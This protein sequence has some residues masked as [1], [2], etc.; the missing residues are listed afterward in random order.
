MVS[1]QSSLVQK[2]VHAV[3][4]AAPTATHFWCLDVSDCGLKELDL[5]VSIHPES[6]G[7]TGSGKVALAFGVPARDSKPG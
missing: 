1:H 2:L 4:L 5:L 6:C 7:Q 3:S